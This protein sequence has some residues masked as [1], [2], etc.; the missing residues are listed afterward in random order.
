M[1]RKINTAQDKMRQ[2]TEKEAPKPSSRPVREG[3]TVEILSIGTKAEV[4]S[5]S[6]DR[7]LTLKAGIMKITLGKDE[8]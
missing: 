7:I 1:R 8:G 3:D 6:Q 5:V 2:T 4:L